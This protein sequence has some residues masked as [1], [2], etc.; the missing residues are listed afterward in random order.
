MHNDLTPLVVL[1]PLLLIVGGIVLGALRARHGYRL[2][3]LAFRERLAAIER[4]VDPAALPAPSDAPLPG[5]GERPAD[6]AQFWYTFG[7]MALFVGVG[8]AI[9]LRCIAPHDEAWF[10]G[11]VPVFSGVGSLVCGALVDRRAQ[12]R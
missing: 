5:T 11:I 12:R 3:E 6:P 9:F 4:G 8:I 7:I 10:L 1:G 2:R